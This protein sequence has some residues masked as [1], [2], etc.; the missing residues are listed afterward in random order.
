ME[1]HGTGGFV[2][3]P[4]RLRKNLTQD[5]NIHH[6][7]DIAVFSRESKPKPSFV[8][9]ILGGGVD[10]AYPIDRRFFSPF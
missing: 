1:I 2:V 8:T 7:D 3:Y 9:G 4:Y 10:P 6:Q 5:A